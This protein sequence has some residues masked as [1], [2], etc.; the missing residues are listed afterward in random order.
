[1]NKREYLSALEAA[2]SGLDGDARSE[3]LGDYEEHFAQSARNGVSDDEVIRALGSV[4]ECAEAVYELIGGA[5]N[6]EPRS[7]A[8]GERDAKSGERANGSAAASD[9]ERANGGAAASDEASRNGAPTELEID[10]FYADI[11][12]LPSSDGKPSSEFFGSK[13][14]AAL[15]YSERRGTAWRIGMKRVAHSFNNNA[16]VQ[17][18]LPSEVKRVT[19]NSGSGNLSIR[20]AAF[21]ELNCETA[22]GDFELSGAVIGSARLRSKSG[23]MSVERC[24]FKGLSMN[25]LSGDAEAL[26]TCADSFAVVTASGDVTLSGISS[27]Q[28]SATTASGDLS[29]RS[30]DCGTLELKT[31]SGDLNVSGCTAERLAAKSASGDVSASVSA[32]RLSAAS[33]S[34]DVDVT[35]RELQIGELN[36][37]SGDVTLLLKDAGG[38]TGSVVTRSGECV[39]AFGGASRRLSRGT[40]TLGDGGAELRLSSV[41]GDIR[42]EC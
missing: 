38:C 5:S 31:A 39:L 22:S 37:V 2:L 30:L 12:I 13:S 1:M 9:G 18:M 24:A 25:T 3:I 17:V 41:S 26:N 36:S 23:D 10:A 40:F 35:A 34:G 11:E 20:G 32:K 29:A 19:F 16:R 4:E 27:K 42:V 28:C 6:A 15:F 14:C 21:A 33:V 8:A 7:N